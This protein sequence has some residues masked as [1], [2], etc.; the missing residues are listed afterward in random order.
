MFQG[1]CEDLGIQI[2]YASVAHPESNG[3]VERA[4]AETLKGPKTHTYDC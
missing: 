3:Q 2:Y 1:Y 4:N